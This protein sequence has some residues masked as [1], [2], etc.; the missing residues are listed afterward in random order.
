MQSKIGTDSLEV[1]SAF[2]TDA[3]AHVY[4]KQ[5]IDGIP[6]A[7]AVAN[8]AFNKD[9]KVV[10]FGS[11]FVTP[12]TS[13]VK[14]STTPSI[15]V[16]EAIAAAEAALEG[17][18]DAENFPAPGLEWFVRDDDSVVLTHVFQVANEEA[19]TWY[20]AFVDAQTGDLVSVTDFVAKA[21]VSSPCPPAD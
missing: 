4:V 5:L 12:K 21:S 3:A 11:S 15:A 6:V 14:P 17:K 9:N 1:G 10:A 13:L 7:N 18:F 19:N 16:E 8:V 2:S 20:E